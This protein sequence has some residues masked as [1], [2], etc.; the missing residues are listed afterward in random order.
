MDAYVALRGSHNATEFSDVEPERMQVAMK[1]LQP[2]VE[3]RVNKTKWVVLRWP[4]PAM[5]QMAGMSTE[6]FEDYYF[7]VCTL[8]YSRM[9]PGMK[10][11]KS[12][13]E[14]HGSGAD[15]RARHRLDV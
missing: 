1:L 13:M 15:H 9:K 7:K 12:L 2:L 8:D 4:T 10:A 11:L 14:K 3:R 6:A 5:A